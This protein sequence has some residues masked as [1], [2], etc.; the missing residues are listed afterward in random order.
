MLR[1]EKGVGL[2]E[3]IIAILIFG[4]GITAALRTLPDSNRATSR[5]RNLSTATNIAQQ[6]IEELMGAGFNDADLSAGTHA[7]A[8]DP[9]ELIYHR[10]WT[11]VDDSP[12]ADMKQVVVTVTYDSGSADNAVSL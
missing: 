3:I 1:S 5:S 7:D 8:V 10:S 2:V 11:V 9:I 4:I 12:L 6:K